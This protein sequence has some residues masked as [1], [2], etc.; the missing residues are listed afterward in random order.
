MNEITIISD[1]HLGSDICQVDRLSKFLDKI[2]TNCLIINGDLFDSWDFRR[3]RKDHWKILKK[4]RQL[5]D[6]IKVV[7]ISGNHDG[8]AELVSHLIGVDFVDEIVLVSA[9]KN[10]LILHGDIFDNF[11]SQYPL[12]TKFADKIYR[13]IQKYDR[14]HQNEYYYS[15]LA[16]RSSKTFLRCSQQIADRALEYCK[17]KNCDVVICGHT[18][19]PLTTQNDLIYYYNSGCWTENSCS[20]ITINSGEVEIKYEGSLDI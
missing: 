8:P 16:K 4:L 15:N 1:I 11:I 18:H 13:L 5:S 2:Q 9:D 12:F 6:K 17:D 7:W 10:V 14:F 20:F 3:L 19:L